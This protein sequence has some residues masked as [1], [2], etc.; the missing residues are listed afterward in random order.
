MNHQALSIRTFIGASDFKESR[1]FYTALGFEEAVISGDLS[2][3]RVNKDLA[4][5][6]QNYFLEAWNHNSMIFLEVK[7]IHQ[8]WADLQALHL[9]ARFPTVRVSAIKNDSW[10]KEYF[11]HDPSGVLWHFGSFNG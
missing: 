6:L 1:A 2:L 10:G 11:V 5:Y 9:P 4:F 7:D 3:F 8:H